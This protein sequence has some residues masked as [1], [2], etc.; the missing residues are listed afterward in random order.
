LVQ[1]VAICP[2]GAV[3]PNG[4][5]D[6]TINSDNESTGLRYGVKGQVINYKEGG[7]Q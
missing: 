2:F 7:T 3:L 5:I 6:A 1:E 4:F